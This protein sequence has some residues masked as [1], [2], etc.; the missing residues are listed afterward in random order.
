MTREELAYDDDDDDDAYYA[1]R[2]IKPLQ[3]SIMT[4]VY[5]LFSVILSFSIWLVYEIG[6]ISVL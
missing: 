6:K 4:E 5:T 2:P 3:K 1:L